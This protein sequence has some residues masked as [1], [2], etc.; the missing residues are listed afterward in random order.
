MQLK[1]WQRRILVFATRGGTLTSDQIDAVHQLFLA[2]SNLCEPQA[3]CEASLEVSGR[4]AE[5]LT[6]SLHL[7]RIDAL[8]GVNALPDGSALTFAP[9][10]TVIYGSSGAGKTG[11]ARVIANACFSRH[12]PEILPN[13]YESGA[14]R[15]ISGA[16]HM[17]VDGVAQAPVAFDPDTD[18]PELRTISFFDTTVARL[19]VSETAAFE[20]KLSGFDVFPEMVRVYGEIGK[21]ID[22]EIAARAHDTK[23]SDSFIGLETPVSKA[24]G[25]INASTDIMA[26]RALAG[27]GPTD[28]ARLVEIDAQLVALKAGSSKEALA[29]LAQARSDI[30]AL[31]A[32]L[33][34]LSGAFTS[35]KAI[36]RSEL[37]KRAKDAAERATKLGIDQFRRAFFDA[38]GSPEWQTFA[39][40]AHALAHKENASY[41]TS[42]DR[43]LLCERP[44]DETSRQHIAALLSFI[45]GDVQRRA[46]AAS[47]ALE[48]E[49]ASLRSLDVE[50][51][52]AESRVR[53]HVRQLD[54]AAESTVADAV[55]DVKALRERTIE[56][57][58]ARSSID[59]AVALGTAIEVLAALRAR[60]DGDINRL[61]KGGATTAIAA[62]ELERQTL[63]HR[64]VLTKL[65]PTIEKRVMDAAWCRKAQAA[66]QALN[67]RHVTDKEKELFTA[68]IGTSYRR[69]LA[70]EC[71][72]LIAGS[73][74]KF[75]RRVRKERPSAPCK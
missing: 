41:P 42:D 28:A 3:G 50:P 43:C 47:R 46:A 6:R 73:P 56:A 20:F 30:D 5:A 67:P 59:A 34:A 32:K 53:E 63:R 65:L 7:R 15:R 57:L 74:L 25:A 38:V 44:L 26:L 4:P 45:E 51:F 13:I 22:A 58:Q 31:L 54:P 8:C 55:A 70:D 49:I 21:R 52:S 35:D 11:F 12:R 33:E 29:I 39:K 66:K 71:G 60:I 2:E 18:Q 10:L 27:Y 37:C 64:E 36:S 72:G 75:K 61:Q 19:R 23:F 16:F 48:T 9:E 14:A 69:R 1:A 62:V 40:A 24:A 17:T 68:I